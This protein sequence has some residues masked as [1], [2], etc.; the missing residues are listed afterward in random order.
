MT[1]HG[2]RACALIALLLALCACRPR[3]D[4]PPGDQPDRPNE[5]WR[6]VYLPQDDQLP[7]LAEEFR[8]NR[9]LPVWEHRFDLRDLFRRICLE[10]LQQPGSLDSRLAGCGRLRSAIV[11]ESATGESSPYD[12]WTVAQKSRLDEI[13]QALVR[14]DA[15]L[16]LSC[17][18]PATS[19]SLR[20]ASDGGTSIFFTAFSG[21]SPGRSRK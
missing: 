7:L 3:E 4:Q 13:F 8:R 17:P 19:Y 1:A 14:E 16:G 12:S 5:N 18:D 2:T 21:C 10:S 20:S 15:D 9:F 11:W 6:E